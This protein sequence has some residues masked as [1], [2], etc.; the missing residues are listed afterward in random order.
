MKNIFVLAAMA[1]ALLYFAWPAEQSSVPA[2]PAAP[3]STAAA[4]AGKAAAPAVPL[5]PASPDSPSWARSPFGRA[6]PLAES[7]PRAIERRKERMKEGGYYTPEAYFTLPLKELQKRAKA[8][9]IYALLQLGQQYYYE[10]PAL[11]EED[12]Y[13]L[14]EDPRFV[15]K[16]HFA[17]AAV[18]GHGQ[19]PAVLTQLYAAEGDM[20]NAYAWRLFGEQLGEHYPKPLDISKLNNQEQ[21]LA[22]QQASLLFGRFM[23]RAPV[24]GIP[25]Q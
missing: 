23:S 7:R 1:A 11:L 25:S 24:G 13:K 18:G 5:V 14:D 3:I 2:A 9:D 17:D 6:A 10:G 12:G 8:G 20:V 4:P 22:K 21:N 16:R 15:G 19:M